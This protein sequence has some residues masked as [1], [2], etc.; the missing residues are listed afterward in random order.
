MSD[1]YVVTASRSNLAKQEIEENA[2]TDSTSLKPIT[3]ETKNLERTIKS[4]YELSNFDYVHSTAIGHCGHPNLETVLTNKPQ[5]DVK[6]N[7]SLKPENE[8]C[9]KFKA[10]TEEKNIFLNLGNLKIAVNNICENKE[11]ASINYSKAVRLSEVST[12]NLTDTVL[13]PKTMFPL[14]VKLQNAKHILETENTVL[15]L[16]HNKGTENSKNH[17]AAGLINLSLYSDTS[18][19]SAEMFGYGK[20]SQT[21][22][23]GLFPNNGTSKDEQGQPTQFIG[24]ICE[25]EVVNLNKNMITS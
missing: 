16:T 12:D 19:S 25:S 9:R 21:P 13:G 18:V 14:N 22:D 1:D 10:V 5:N 7:A 11:N 6:F 15:N 8:V 4:F 23:S 17:N 24:Y 2:A 20:T 3:R